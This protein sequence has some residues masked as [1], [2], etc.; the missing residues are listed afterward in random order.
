MKCEP[1]TLRI[2]E[3]KGLSFFLAAALLLLTAQQLSAEG[4]PP[5]GYGGPYQRTPGN[6]NNLE[7]KFQAPG[8]G[9]SAGLPPSYADPRFIIRQREGSS[10]TEQLDTSVPDGFVYVNGAVFMMGG[11]QGNI[12]TPAH[13]VAVN[14][15]WISPYEVYWKLWTDVLKWAVD[16]GYKFAH[17]GKARQVSVLT[18]LDNPVHNISWYDAIVWCNAYSEIR[19]LEPVYRYNSTVSNNVVRNS[20]NRLVRSSIYIDLNANGYRLPTEAEWEF[21]ARG[22]VEARGYLF[23]GSN[24]EV[25][26]AWYKENTIGKRY[27]HS[28]GL[29]RPNTLGL[30][31][32][33]GNLAEWVS[34]WYGED[35]YYGS[36]VDN[37][38]GP[39]SGRY[40][41]VRGGS[42]KTPP[43]EDFY[44]ST[45]KLKNKKGAWISLEMRE[46]R[47]PQLISNSIGFRPARTAIFR[48]IT[49]LADGT[50]TEN[51]NKQA[52]L[53]KQDGLSNPAN[54]GNIN[55][56]STLRQD[57][58]VNSSPAQVNTTTNNSTPYIYSLDPN[59][60]PNSTPYRR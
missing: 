26:V 51:S 15:F 57:R 4:M 10:L 19:G 21:A 60:I 14:S 59:Y 34:D 29:L 39:G 2:A 28:V 22:G 12:K 54:I 5:E 17:T 7:Q 11:E 44:R 38:L 30:Y 8:S 23:A 6:T 49:Y 37:P 41:V 33:N 24:R 46:Y 48:P 36:P 9:L 13:R 27:G 55:N 20:S 35:Y 45:G 1:P 56:S 25:D 43:R 32:M 3:Y 58:P 16:H 42:F 47:K 40:K 31:D 53:V 52:Q 50:S 18:G